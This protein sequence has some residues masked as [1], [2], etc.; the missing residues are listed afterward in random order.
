[1][2]Y[3]QMENDDIFTEFWA[4]NEL[5]ELSEMCCVGKIDT[6]VLRQKVS[7]VEDVLCKIKDTIVKV[8][9]ENEK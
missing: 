4:S 8:E 3:D 9:K 7:K 2:I 6:D 5:Q 1:M